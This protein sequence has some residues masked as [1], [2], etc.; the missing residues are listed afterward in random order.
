MQIISQSETWKETSEF[1]VELCE[2]EEKDEVMESCMPCFKS[3]KELVVSR[4]SS[5]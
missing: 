5:K 2:T 3:E 4:R 1:V